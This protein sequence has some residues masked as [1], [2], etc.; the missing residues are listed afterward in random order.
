MASGVYNREQRTRYQGWSANRPLLVADAPAAE[1]LLVARTGYTAYVTKIQISV[2]TL[3][4]TDA[5]SL[6]DS[7]GTPVVIAALTPLPAAADGLSDLGPHFW[8]FGEEGAPLTVSTG[9][10]LTASAGNVAYIHVEGYWKQTLPLGEA[11]FK[12][13]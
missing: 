8:D 9:L 12:T 10:T 11:T 5:I 3:G 1:V 4:T 6:Q 7:A 2:T 13:T